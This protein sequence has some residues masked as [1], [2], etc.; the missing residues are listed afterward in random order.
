MSHTAVMTHSRQAQVTFFEFEKA[1]KN[2]LALPPVPLTTTTRRENQKSL[3]TF[4]IYA[5][6]LPPISNLHS[7]IYRHLVLIFEI[8]SRIA[9]RCSTKAREAAARAEASAIGIASEPRRA[10]GGG[11][12]CGSMPREDGG[13]R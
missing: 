6:S 7:S 9:S 5:L 1:S 13:M 12:C 8:R 10:A 3:P 4:K 2:L 11:K